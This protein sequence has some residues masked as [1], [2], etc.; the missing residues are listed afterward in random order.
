MQIG[1]DLIK[2][3]QANL[4]WPTIAKKKCIIL[5]LLFIVLFAIVGFLAFKWTILTHTKIKKITNKRRKKKKT[6]LS[7]RSQIRSF[8]QNVCLIDCLCC[9]LD[10]VFEICE[11]IFRRKIGDVWTTEQL[12]AV[13]GLSGQYVYCICLG[14]MV[15][16]LM[17]FEQNTRKFSNAFNLATIYSYFLLYPSVSGFFFFF[18]SVRYAT[19]CFT[20]DFR[21]GFINVLMCVGPK[22]YT[23]DHLFLHAKVFRVD[24][25]SSLWFAFI[26]NCWKRSSVHNWSMI[27]FGI[28]ILFILWATFFVSIFFWSIF[29]NRSVNFHFENGLWKIS[30]TYNYYTFSV[31]L[32]MHIV[33]VNVISS[34]WNRSVSHVKKYE[35]ID[36]DLSK[37]LKILCY[38]CFAIQMKKDQRTR[39]TK[40]KTNI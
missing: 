36:C 33:N 26:P 25:T 28:C 19:F 38:C 10:C 37:G 12:L 21:F 30:I 35:W 22:S 18:L 16:W 8:I 23:C 13:S 27:S 4:W 24:S 5:R 39:K 40:I 20:V 32:F 34:E 11:P 29:E 3:E 2:C 6:K 1:I 15:V 14:F 7:M 17:R 9:R 31:S